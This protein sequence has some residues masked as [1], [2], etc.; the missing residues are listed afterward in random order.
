M[1]NIQ[2]I[3]T[4]EEIKT[5]TPSIISLYLNCDQ[6]VRTP[7]QIRITLKNLSKEIEA[8]ADKRTLSKIKDYIKLRLKPGTRGLA[9]FVCPKID[10]W[11]IYEVPRAFFNQVVCD[12][13]PYTR[14]LIKLLDEFERYCVV[15][16]DKEKAR[17]FTVYLGE[18]EERK[19]VFSLPKF[20]GKHDQG[21]WRQ[22]RM[23]RH[24]E[25]HITRLINSIAKQIFSF[26]RKNNFDRLIIAGSKEV[27]PEFEK[28]IHSYLKQRLAGKFLTE[29]FMPL[30]HF[31]DQSLKI[32]EQ[33]ERQKESELVS[34]LK[35]SI[36]RAKGVTGLGKVLSAAQRKELQTL[37]VLIGFRRKG[38]VCDDCG[39]IS[40]IPQL[41]VCPYCKEKMKEAEDVI[42]R[43]L[44]VA[45]E[46]DA[47]VEFVKDNKDLE[48]MGNIGAI[49]R[50]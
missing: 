33:V 19:D 13:S 47:K 27:L 2:E 37:L 24:T 41:K 50:F 11:K 10:L 49:L 40:I 9:F 43:L 48:K 44:E 39:F 28:N 34:K 26:F 25:V 3:K 31:L 42:E 30:K 45:L 18:I 16:L 21:G 14:P 12:T 15:V 20:P 6:R 5:K 32:E 35:E 36:G 17:V 29:M 7:E 23:Q 22:A 46:Q 1:L 4:L 38:K 8:K